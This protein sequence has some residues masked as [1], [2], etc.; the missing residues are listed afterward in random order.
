MPTEWALPSSVCNSDISDSSTALPGLDLVPLKM[1]KTSVHE[2][3]VDGRG[4]ALH[5]PTLGQGTW[6]KKEDYGE[7]GGAGKT[8]QKKG[9]EQRDI[10]PSSGGGGPRTLTRPED[11]ARP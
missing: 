2:H 3:L 10:V 4:G 9:K 6:I 8:E 11:W 1:Q 5:P 7:R